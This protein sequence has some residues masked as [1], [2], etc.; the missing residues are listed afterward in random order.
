MPREIDGGRQLDE[1]ETAVENHNMA[2]RWTLKGDGGINNFDCH[3]GPV[4]T[5]RIQLG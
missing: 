2:F 4:G 3:I 1:L 5:S